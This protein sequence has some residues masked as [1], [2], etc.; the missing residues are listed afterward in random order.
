VGVLL[1]CLVL[2]RDRLALVDFI[3]V[4]EW[5]VAHFKLEILVSVFK[6]VQLVC[7]FVLLPG[8]V[9]VVQL[10]SMFMFHGQRSGFELF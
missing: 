4:A 10:V 7:E 2:G 9:D 3:V 5:I 8:G 6:L 1:R